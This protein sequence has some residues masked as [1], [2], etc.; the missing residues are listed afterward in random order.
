MSGGPNSKR[1]ERGAGGPDLQEFA[2]N[3][4][5]PMARNW[6]GSGETTKRPDGKSRA[7]Q[8]EYMA[9]QLWQTP[10][11]ADVTGGRTS[12]S[13]ERI[14]EVFLIGQARRLM[15]WATPQARDHF[16]P[17]SPERIRAKVAEGHGMRNLNDEAA[18]WQ[19]P[20]ATDGEKGGP[21][22]TFGTGGTPLPAQASSLR[23]RLTYPVGGIPSKERRSLNPLFVEWLMGWP[24]GWTLG[25]WTDLGCSATALSRWRLRMHSA[26]L[27]IALPNAGPPAQLGLFR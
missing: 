27:A 1:D 13:G 11:A 19:T 18:H 23:D 8:L 4:P 15:D 12:R 10:A 25:A 14:D 21:N 2:T 7:D 16:P 5:T 20:R 24:P 26:L 3:W 9:E 17:H 22:Q 6:K